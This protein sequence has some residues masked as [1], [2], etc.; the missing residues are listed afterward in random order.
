[1]AHHAGLEL[2]SRWATFTRDPFTADS[3]FHV[4]VYRRP[5]T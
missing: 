5:L 4:S 2:E 1:M 3:P